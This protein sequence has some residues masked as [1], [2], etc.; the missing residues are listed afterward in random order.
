LARAPKDHGSGGASALAEVSG[1]GVSP[2]RQ[3]PTLW[4]LV[5]DTKATS[6]STAEGEGGFA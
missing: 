6:G 2:E 4:T 3:K 1:R 5:G